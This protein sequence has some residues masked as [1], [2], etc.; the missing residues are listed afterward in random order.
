MPGSS[1]NLRHSSL[2]TPW[3]S[4]DARR[5][6]NTT[7]RG[8]VAALG[9]FPGRSSPSVSHGSHLLVPACP[10]PCLHCP[11]SHPRLL[12]PCHGTALPL[13]SRGSPAQPFPEGAGGQRTGHRGKHLNAGS[14][15]FISFLLGFL[16]ICSLALAGSCLRGNAGCSDRGRVLVLAPSSP[17]GPP[18]L[19]G[20]HRGG[21]W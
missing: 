8:W 19:P 18:S 9:T 1:L 10:H 2:P 17:P 11:D 5:S 4:A 15:Y 12:C 20:T 3:Q 14:S 21:C 13:A 16:K 6:K 7:L